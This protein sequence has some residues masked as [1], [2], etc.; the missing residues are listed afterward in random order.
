MTW[1]ELTVVTNGCFEERVE[2]YDD[3]TDDLTLVLAEA[4]F[5]QETV[6]D[7]MAQGHRVEIYTVTHECDPT[8]DDDCVCAQYE[9]DHRP[10]VTVGAA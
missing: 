3:D 1:R 2:F 4:S 9:T 5:I 10:I 8:D 7:A 6:E